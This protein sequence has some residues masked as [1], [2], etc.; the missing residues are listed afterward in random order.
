MATGCDDSTIRLWS[1]PC[2][3]GA[4]EKCYSAR[5][6]CAPDG[7]GGFAC[8]GTCASGTR[9]CLKPG[10]WGRCVG[11]VLPEEDLPSNGKDEDCNGTKDG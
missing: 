2:S 11:E 7:K 6:G 1:C 5:T 8:A 3:P 9:T 4:T 10:R